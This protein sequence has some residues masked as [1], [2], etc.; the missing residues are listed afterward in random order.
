ML[1]LM[2]VLPKMLKAKEVTPQLAAVLNNTGCAQPRDAAVA[3]RVVVG[4]IQGQN[5]QQI[6]KCIIAYAFAQQLGKKWMG[7]T[8]LHAATVL[9]DCRADI[10]Q[11]RVVQQ[12]AFDI[13]TQFLQISHCRHKISEHNA[14]ADADSVIE[15]NVEGKIF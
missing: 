10:L 15:R 4:R 8:H 9:G 3:S 13:H 12:A 1:L 7:T 6:V 2:S 5:L 14:S 11:S